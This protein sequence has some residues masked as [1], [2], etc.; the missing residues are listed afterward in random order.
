MRNHSGPDGSTMAVRRRTPEPW[1]DPADLVAGV[2]T[3]CV[4]PHAGRWEL[5]RDGV[6]LSTH[7]TRDDALD[8]AYACSDREFS[9]ILATGSTGRYLFEMEQDPKLLKLYRE[10]DRMRG[11]A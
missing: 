11:L 5:R 4:T 3:L 9:N 8:S 2:P 1:Y 6:L 7:A 10:L